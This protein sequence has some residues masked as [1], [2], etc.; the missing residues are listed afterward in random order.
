MKLL[1]NKKNNAFTLL[2]LLIYIAILSILTVGVTSAFLSIN[3][4]RGQI[5]SR[6]EVN[7]NIQFVI[8]KINQDLNSSSSI[9]NPSNAGSSSTTLQMITDG[10]TVIYFLSQGKIY[11]KLNSQEPEILTSD[12][13]FVEEIKF[14]RLENT[15]L[16]LNKKRITIETDI[17]MRYNSDSPDYQYSMRKKTTFSLKSF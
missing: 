13:V 14:T 17:A 11:R 3:R 10:S 12:K 4:G 5:Q 15:N 6:N 7:T 2:E 1:K 9:L 16:I 8:E